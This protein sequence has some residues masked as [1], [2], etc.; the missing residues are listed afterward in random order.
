MFKLRLMQNKIFFLNNVSNTWTS[1]ISNYNYDF[2]RSDGTGQNFYIGN[3]NT[4]TTAQSN[5]Y[6]SGPNNN[7]AFSISVG[8]GNTTLTHDI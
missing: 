2:R 6:F 5:L 1:N 4:T 7:S 3:S 8:N